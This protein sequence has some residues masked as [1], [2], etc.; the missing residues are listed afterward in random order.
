MDTVRRGVRPTTTKRTHSRSTLGRTQRRGH[1]APPSGPHPSPPAA[2][3]SGA[4][5]ARRRLSLASPPPPRIRLVRLSRPRARAAELG[6]G[7]RAAVA[8]HCQ[9]RRGDTRMRM[10][11]CA[12]PRA[13]VLDALPACP[14]PP[15]ASSVRARD[16]RCVLPLHAAAVPT[17]PRLVFNVPLR[18]L[19][20]YPSTPLLLFRRVLCAGV[21]ASSFMRMRVDWCGRFPLTMLPTYT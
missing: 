1:H 8:G 10:T 6:S 12:V 20:H 4:A 7:P 13:E 14:S 2:T 3:D 17:S 16:R 21:S 19:D 15:P 18:Y 5:G 9:L 11:V